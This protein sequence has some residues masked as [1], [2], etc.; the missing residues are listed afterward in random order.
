M[1]RAAGEQPPPFP[2][3]PTSGMLQ[4]LQLMRKSTPARIDGNFLRVNRIAPGNEY[5]VV[6]ALR[7][8]GVINDEGRPTEKSRRLKT[9]GVA[10][11][12]GLQELVREAYA[13]LFQYLNGNGFSQEDIYNYFVTEEGLGTEMAAKTTRFFIHLCRMAEIELGFNKKRVS[14]E[15]NKTGVSNRKQ[16]AQ[17]QTVTQLGSLN[18][19]PLILALTPETASMDTNELTEFFKKLKV[20]ISKAS[21]AD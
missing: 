1:V 12:S 19:F 6:G 16:A 15:S 3:G 10:F 9:K 7:F 13:N 20:A 8:L 4:A 21:T 17:N 2:Y 5:K 11:I 18:G 14:S